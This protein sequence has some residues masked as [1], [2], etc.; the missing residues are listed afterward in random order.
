MDARIS[1]ET[2]DALMA[3]VS[4]HQ[5]LAREIF[6]YRTRRMGL[7]QGG[8]YADLHASI[9]LGGDPVTLTW[10]QA[11]ELVGGAFSQTYPALGEFFRETVWKRWIDYTPR[12]GKRPGAF[13]TTSLRSGESRVF[14]T[15]TGALGEVITLAHEIGHAWHARVLKT[16]R[17][18]AAQYPMTLAESAS[19]FAE[20]LVRDGVLS[21]PFSSSSQLA[22]LEADTQRAPVFLLELPI[23]YH[24]E[25]R[26]HEERLSGPV[27]VSRLSELMVETQREVFGDALGDGGE[28]PFFWCSKLHFYIDDVRFY[29]FPYVFGYL[30]SQALH[31]RLVAEGP[32]FL[33]AYERFLAGSGG[34]SCERIVKQALGEDLGS[35][36]FWS[37]AIRSVEA[38]YLALRSRL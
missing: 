3:A 30:L 1:R 36:E 13:C 34:G 38:P 4:Q 9:P 17:P 8:G 14:M 32:S 12:A 27:S 11:L 26:F 24:F 5:E 2:L 37:R 6:R 29:N 21:G 10:E 18:L 20:L 16:A 7:V 23:R 35:V 31:V 28:D 22:L 25:R 19:T 33:P 15:F